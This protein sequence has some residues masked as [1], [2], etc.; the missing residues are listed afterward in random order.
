MKRENVERTV[1]AITARKRGSRKRNLGDVS[2]VKSLDRTMLE[3]TIEGLGLLF[4]QCLV[5]V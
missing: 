5:R 1:A 2:Q 3:L 4:L